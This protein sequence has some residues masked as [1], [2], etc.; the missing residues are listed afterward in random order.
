MF[1][2]QQ[3]LILISK[4]C[5]KDTHNKVC[6]PKSLYIKMAERPKTD[7]PIWKSVKLARERL[8]TAQKTA[9]NIQNLHSQRGVTYHWL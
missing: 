3:F 1:L 8:K 4:K 7:E 5:S 2:M 9:Q 6:L